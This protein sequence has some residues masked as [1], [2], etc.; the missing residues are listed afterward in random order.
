VGHRG[1]ACGTAGLDTAA[2][3]VTGRAVCCVVW[4]GDCRPPR[5]RGPGWELLFE[6]PACVNKR[7]PS[8]SPAGRLRPNHHRTDVLSHTYND[9]S[10]AT[11][12]RQSYICPTLPRP[13]RPSPPRSPA[14]FPSNPPPRWTRRGAPR[15]R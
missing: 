15:G 13:R 12:L 9:G 4:G 11:F 10:A 8:I 7:L 1:G 14:T 5:G 6:P 2:R 3:R